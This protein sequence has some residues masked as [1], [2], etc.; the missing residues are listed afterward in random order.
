MRH[1]L[2][3]KFGIAGHPGAFLEAVALQGDQ[4]EEG[5]ALYRS[6][7]QL[8]TCRRCLPVLGIHMTVSDPVLAEKIRNGVLLD[9]VEGAAADCL[10]IV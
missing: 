5:F 9:L 7:A 10:L 3:G 6:I 8:R 1:V 4:G 2:H